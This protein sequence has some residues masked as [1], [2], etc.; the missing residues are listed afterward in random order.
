M[1]DPTAPRLDDTAHD[2][3]GAAFGVEYLPNLFT[4]PHRQQIVV[5]LAALHSYDKATGDLGDQAAL[6]A[7]Y[8]IALTN[9]WILR[10]DVM[11]GVVEEGNTLAGLR[12]EIR[13]KW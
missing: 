11:G 12:A 8:Q 10:F 13:K 5:E 4:A 2:R 3:V 7:R 9:S 1:D 6:G